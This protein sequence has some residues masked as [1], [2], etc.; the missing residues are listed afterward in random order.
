MDRDITHFASAKLQGGWSASDFSKYLN[1]ENLAMLL[2]KFDK[3]DPLVR[4][5][6]L[7]SVLTLDDATKHS[8][9]PDLEVPLSVDYF[10][11]SHYLPVEIVITPLQFSQFIAL[12]ST[13]CV[14]KQT[15]ACRISW[16]LP[17]TTRR[18]GSAT[19][20][21]PWAISRPLWTCRQSWPA[22]LW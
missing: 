6:L 7:L 11:V 21:E 10:T 4:V 15:A 9:Q 20:P 1:R 12:L 2:P 13:R 14:V 16:Q 8:L 18:S 22:P 5:R 3:L 17:K 19:L